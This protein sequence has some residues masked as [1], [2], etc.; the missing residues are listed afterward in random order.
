M[1]RQGG[2]RKGSHAIW[3]YWMRQTWAGVKKRA[4][5]SL[6]QKIAELF[7]KHS[8]MTR[9]LDDYEKYIIVI[10]MSWKQTWRWWHTWHLHT[11]ENYGPRLT[12]SSERDIKNSEFP[13]AVHLHSTN[14][15]HVMPFQKIFVKYDTDH[16]ATHGVEMLHSWASQYH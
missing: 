9:I 1:D 7:Q 3:C 8:I 2:E 11:S 10:E 13:H 15:S 14:P 12:T 5:R 4:L 6:P 16:S